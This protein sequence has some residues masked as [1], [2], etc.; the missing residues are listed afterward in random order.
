MN[1]PM[2]PVAPEFLADYMWTPPSKTA[3]PTR[4]ELW[5]MI[6]AQWSHRFPNLPLLSARDHSCTDQR[7]QRIPIHFTMYYQPQGRIHVCT[8]FCQIMFGNYVPWHRSSDELTHMRS[9]LYRTCA[10]TGLVHECKSPECRRAAVDGKDG[11]WMCL[12]S[13][14]QVDRQ[15]DSG[16]WQRSDTFFDE[17]YADRDDQEQ[18]QDTDIIADQ[19]FGGDASEARAL[20]D[21]S[22]ELATAIPTLRVGRRT[23]RLM[24]AAADPFAA[25]AEKARATSSFTVRRK[26]PGAAPA[27]AADNAVVPQ[28]KIEETIFKMLFSEQRRAAETKHHGDVYDHADRQVRRYL[29]DRRSLINYHRTLDR[30]GKKATGRKRGLPLPATI[31]SSAAAAAVVVAPPAKLPRLVCSWIDMAELAQTVANQHKPPINIDIPA[32]KKRRFLRYYHLMVIALRTM[33]LSIPKVRDELATSPDIQRVFRPVEFTEA[34]LYMLRNGLRVEHNFVSVYVI[35]PDTFLQVCL[36]DPSMLHKHRFIEGPFTTIK[37][38]IRRLIF[39]YTRSVDVL[40]ADFPIDASL[41]SE[42]LAP[43]DPTEDLDSVVARVQRK[44]C[45]RY[46]NAVAS[47]T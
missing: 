47:S 35:P 5:R 3:I 15:I 21:Q 27:T 29:G 24:D 36:P 42:I 13:G 20:L 18:L 26:A 45:E 40:P 14:M 8:T 22:S 12:V 28:N 44:M 31:A 30:G 2:E 34:A 25:A 43:A 6:R 32:A 4:T 46:I 10:T 9:T 39:E 16:G 41:L 1:A 33:L 19:L 11:A 23:M 37:N 17:D 38:I 7:C